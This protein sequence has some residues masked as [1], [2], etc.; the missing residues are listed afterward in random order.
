M[1][2]WKVVRIKRNMVYE[3]HRTVAGTHHDCHYEKMFLL[4]NSWR[5]GVGQGKEQAQ[6]GGSVCEGHIHRYTIHLFF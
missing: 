3:V 4:I 6:K 1:S 2:S 5:S